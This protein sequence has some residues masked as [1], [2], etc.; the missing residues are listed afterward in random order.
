M[1]LYLVIAS[2]PAV[3]AGMLVKDQVE[4]FFSDPR[5][6]AGFLLVTAAFLLAAEWLGKRNRKL[7]SLTW[8]DALVMGLFQAL[9][10]L[11][12]IS[13]SGST[14]TGGM[15]RDLDRPAAARFSFLMAVPV[16]L[17]SSL[18]AGLDI[19]GSADLLAHAGPFMLGMAVAG[20]IGFTAIHY[21]LRFLASRPIAWFSPYLVLLAA[22]VFILVA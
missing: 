17:G 19:L 15:L 7:E 4:A 11:P 16:M 8:L 14:I 5:A 13:R 22:V 6:T 9:A 18:L 12:G 20:V 3:I 1:G 10:L 2:L 21:L